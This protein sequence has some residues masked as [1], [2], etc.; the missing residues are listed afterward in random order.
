MP[1]KRPGYDVDGQSLLSLSK[2][3]QRSAG[4]M[5]LAGLTL[6]A[7]DC[8]DQ[9]QSLLFKVLA[10]ELRNM[11]FDLAL[12]LEVYRTSS[13]ADII[14]SLHTWRGSAGKGRICCNI[15]TALL[16]T[17]R[18]IYVETK[19]TPV[20]NACH[21]FYGYRPRLLNVIRDPGKLEFFVPSSAF[22]AFLF[23]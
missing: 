15:D 11:I 1:L 8:N 18:L 7:S 17:C 9:Q 14:A 10:P 13:E 12:Q 2:K 19:F 3:A 22:F 23:F 5:E 4:V 6:V 20:Y 16:R 21:D